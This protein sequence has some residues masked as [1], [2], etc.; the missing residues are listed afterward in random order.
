MSIATRGALASGFSLHNE[1]RE[2]GTREETKPLVASA[3]IVVFRDTKKTKGGLPS[4]GTYKSSREVAGW[5][6]KGRRKEL[7]PVLILT[8]AQ[9]H[10]RCTITGT[11]R[12]RFASR[13]NTAVVYLIWIPSAAEDP[14]SFRGPC[15][16]P[17]T[18]AGIPTR[19]AGFRNNACL[20]GTHEFHFC[21]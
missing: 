16:S 3:A 13:L 10:P 4:E 18:I 19:F 12:L 2:S 20:L 6:L 15:C 14:H 17:G 11:K 9:K 8:R 5:E 7:K 21:I 1:A